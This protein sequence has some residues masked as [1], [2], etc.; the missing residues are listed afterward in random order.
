MADSLKKLTD[1]LSA[2]EASMEEMASL[3][4]DERSCI[5]EFNT[6]RLHD[7]GSRKAQVLALMEE[8]DGTC[9]LLVAQAGKELGIP[10]SASLSPIIARCTSPV[11]EELKNLQTRLSKTSS[12]VQELLA[13][14]RRLLE[15]SL[16]MVGRSLT[17]FQGRFKV[18]DT[19]GGSGRMVERSA[20][21][22]MLQKEL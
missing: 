17:F 13:D 4:R 3:L 6:E 10:G 18:A 21:V 9:R 19:Y 22:R 20:N 11:R 8:L 15:S 2:R 12:E 5:I 7:N 14:N 16:A 1:V